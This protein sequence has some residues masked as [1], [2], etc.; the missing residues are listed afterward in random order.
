MEDGVVMKRA[1]QRRELLRLA[2]EEIIPKHLFGDP[3]PAG[4]SMMLHTRQCPNCQVG[5]AGPVPG[6]PG[7]WQCTVCGDTY[8]TASKGSVAE[9]LP[10][11]A[12]FYGGPPFL[13]WPSNAQHRN[14]ASVD[15]KLVRKGDFRGA[16]SQFLIEVRDAVGGAAEAKVKFKIGEV[17]KKALG[18]GDLYGAIN[19]VY[20]AEEPVADIEVAEEKSVEPV[21]VKE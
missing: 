20:S 12:K 13:S 15:G 9:Q 1:I 3:T 4:E 17:V 2:K 16:V 14:T 6:R 10:Y 18:D 8:N 11:D 19:K 5:Q 7:I 21:V